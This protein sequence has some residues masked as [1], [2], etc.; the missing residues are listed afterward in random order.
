MLP[1][2]SN[3]VKANGLKGG[4]YLEPFAGGSGLALSLIFNKVVSEIFLNDIDRSIYAFWNSVL[5]DTDNFIEHIRKIP[6]SIE[7]WHRQREIQKNKESADLFELG[8][9]SFYLNRTNRSG[10]IIKAGVIGGIKQDGRYRMDCRF[11]KQNLIMRIQRI[12][13]YKDKIHLYNLDAVEFMQRLICQLPEDTLFFIDP[14]YYEKGHT[15]YTDFYQNSDH[16][17]LANYIGTMR[18]PWI[19][20]YDCTPSIAN[21]Y[22]VGH[23][24]TYNLNYSLA[25]KRV[26]QELL[27]LSQSLTPLENYIPEFLNRKF[28]LTSLNLAYPP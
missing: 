7:E 22:G 18:Q 27:I 24:Y 1:I 13:K 6:I 21:L 11:N 26:G 25:R 12:A 28:S 2:V 23:H 5:N 17:D 19:L 4:F 20:T 14:P 8:L 9:S 10:I 3:I 16:Q 15:L